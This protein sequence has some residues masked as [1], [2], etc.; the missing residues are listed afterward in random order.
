LKEAPDQV[1]VHIYVNGLDQ[2]YYRSTHWEGYGNRP[3]SLPK[4]GKWL[5]ELI[6]RAPAGAAFVLDDL[7]ISS[8]ARYANR[9]VAFGPQ[10]TFNPF[11][12][13]PP[14]APAKADKDTRLLFRFDNNLEDVTGQKIGKLK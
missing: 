3:F 1:V 11:T 8:V 12:F 14:D 4:D 13:S 9:E 6:S 5:Q 10:Q 7:R 2:A